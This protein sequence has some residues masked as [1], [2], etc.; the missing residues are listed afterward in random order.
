M[1]LLFILFLYCDVCEYKETKYKYN[2]ITDSYLH[3]VL[4]L[5]NTILLLAYKININN[6]YIKVTFCI[7]LLL[8]VISYLLGKV[9][10]MERLFNEI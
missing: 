8:R 9:R 3:L 6:I 5:C 4:I 1:E 2:Y 7:W 10:L